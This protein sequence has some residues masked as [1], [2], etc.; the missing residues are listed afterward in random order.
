MSLQ[1]NKERKAVGQIHDTFTT[2]EEATLEASNGR[3]SMVRS[4]LTPSAFAK[5]LIPF[6]FVET[7]IIIPSLLK[8]RHGEA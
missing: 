6:S 8:R 3:F 5:I 1:V 7:A 4:S 2:A